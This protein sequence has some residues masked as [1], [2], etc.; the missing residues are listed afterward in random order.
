MKVCIVG[1]TVFPL[2][3]ELGAE[4]IDVM[5]EYP[6]G[7][8]F[9]TRGSVGFD[10]FVV[11]VCEILDL[12]L[13]CYPSEGGSKNWDRDVKIVKDADEVVVFL[14]PA[15]LD[16]QNTGT[17]HILAKALDQRKRTR[18]FTESSGHLVFAGDTEP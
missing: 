14:D 2:S 12:P 5:R 15:T 6:D 8:M 4:V 3:P 17:A 13:R 1:S 16:D 18:A 10:T 11:T 9:L 7:T